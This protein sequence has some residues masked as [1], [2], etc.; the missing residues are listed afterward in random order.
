MR[1]HRCGESLSG[2][3]PFLW[4]SKSGPPAGFWQLPPGGMCVC[5]FLFVRRGGKILLGKYRDD[6]RWEALAGLDSGRR[7][8]H[9]KRL[10]IPAS[11]MKFGE[12]PRD[13]AKRVGEEVLKIPGMTY[14]EP[15]VEVDLY[16]STDFPGN[17]HSDLW[18]LVDATPP[19]GWTL[20]VPP[21][22]ADLA[23]HD[24]RTLAAEAYARGHED[25]V[26]R[27]RRPRL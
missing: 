10:T 12:D 18:F 20:K 16:P 13:A 5:A 1:P 3:G 22:Y 19:K 21:W 8:R 23:W 15:R 14:A 2:E 26:A 7:Q 4:L 11:H 25:V 24:P 27:W 6:P 17:M 9:G